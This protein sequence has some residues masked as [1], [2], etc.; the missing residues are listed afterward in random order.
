MIVRTLLHSRLSIVQTTMETTRTLLTDC[1]AHVKDRVGLDAKLAQLAA[2]GPANLQIITDFDYTMS[3]AHKGGAPVDC[4]WGVL[5]NYSK[6]P[7]TYTEKVKILRD[8]YYPIEVD[9]SIPVDKKIP[10]M[11][12]WY[13]KANLLLAESGVRADWFSVMVSE[14][15]CELRD[16]T[17]Q[18][19]SCLH[20]E[21]IPLIV[22]SAGIGD[23]IQEILSHFKVLYDNV[24]IVSNFLEFDS[25]TGSVLGL[26]TDPCIHMYNKRAPSQEG[27]EQRKNIILI[28]DSIGDVSMAD[29]IQ[30]INVSLKI[31]FLNKNVEGN[32]PLYLD[33]FDVV[34][35]DDQTMN[36][37]MAI[38]EDILNEKLK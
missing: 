33:K 23:L 6:L 27:L 12:E 36:F 18:L 4:S 38:I 7:L 29:G 5:E 10:L 37:P 35:V 25:K 21:N 24:R 34:L 19:L 22:L 15:N 16:S 14:S 9:P 17:D 13:T 8:K 11:S 28:G 2:G 1:R 26:K 31:G 32:L 30:G 20:R 3:R